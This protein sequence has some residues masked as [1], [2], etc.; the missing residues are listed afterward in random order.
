MP[1]LQV[2]RAGNSTLI[3]LPQEFLNRFQLKEGDLLCVVETPDR[4]ELAPCDAELAKQVRVAELVMRQ[5]C[6]ILRRFG[7]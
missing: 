5:D 4:I 2:M 3:K 1:P 7:S 6:E